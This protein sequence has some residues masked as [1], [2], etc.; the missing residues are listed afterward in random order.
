[1][2]SFRN[3]NS[4]TKFKGYNKTAKVVPEWLKFEE[5]SPHEG[6]GRKYGA[7][8]LVLHWALLAL[9][10][11]KWVMEL[12]QGLAYWSKLHP[13]DYDLVL[14]IKMEMGKPWAEFEAFSL[15]ICNAEDRPT[16]GY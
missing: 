11:K 6:V 2:S 3:I 5:C 1:M 10:F 13:E 8:K 9:F 7:W 14:I 12:S 16:E 4:S 15:A